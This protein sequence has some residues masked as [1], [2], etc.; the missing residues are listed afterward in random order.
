MI[1][2]VDL[3]YV[4]FCHPNSC[5]LHDWC[6]CNLGC[7]YV[8]ISLMVLTR[9]ATKTQETRLCYLVVSG[10]PLDLKHHCRIYVCSECDGFSIRQVS[11]QLT[12]FVSKF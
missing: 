10:T 1:F 9:E 4:F 6:L 7:L 3:T 12:L 11:Y 8:A 2:K 5:R